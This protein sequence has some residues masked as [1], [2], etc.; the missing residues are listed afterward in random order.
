[1]VAS[2]QQFNPRLHCIVL[3]MTSG[4]N[5]N[6][7]LN[8]FELQLYPEQTNLLMFHYQFM[9]NL[10]ELQHYPEQTSLL[11]NG[12]LPLMICCQLGLVFMHSILMT[13]EG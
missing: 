5:S 7:Y 4:G 6:K 10:R 8:L 11:I 3:T 2:C 9:I 1:M 12:S 13:K